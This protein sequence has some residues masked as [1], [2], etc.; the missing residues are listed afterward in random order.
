M[1]RQTPVQT[2]THV[3]SEICHCIFPAHHTVMLPYSTQ[4]IIQHVTL[5][6]VLQ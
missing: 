1:E 5:S 6:D 3:M 4:S 2:R